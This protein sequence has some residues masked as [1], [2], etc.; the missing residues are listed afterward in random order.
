[1]TGKRIL[2]I[3][4]AFATIALG[5]AQTRLAVSIGGHPAGYATLSQKIQKDGSKVVELRIELTSQ[6]NKVRITSQASYDDKGLPTRK[7]QETTGPGSRHG[8]AV[9]T[10]DGDGANAVIQVDTKRSV[11]HVSL[12]KTAPRTSLSEFWFIRDS[13]KPGQIEKTYQFNPDTLT[14]ELATTEYR[15]KKKLTIEGHSLEVY[16]V[17]TKRGDKESM[18]YLDEQ[19]LPVLVDLGNVKM[20][21]IWPK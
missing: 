5:S 1:M 4:V 19:G 21:K 18:S 11:K 12:V 17:V 7:F 10:F 14:W 9:V 20:V 15:G 8:Q 13:P 2:L 16:E 6:G 3:I